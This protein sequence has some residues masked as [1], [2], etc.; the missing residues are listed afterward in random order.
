MWAEIPK[1]Q[2]ETRGGLVVNSPV[3]GWIQWWGYAALYSNNT[4]PKILPSGGGKISSA[5]SGEKRWR[6]F[7]KKM[8]TGDVIIIGMM[9]WDPELEIWKQ[10]RFYKDTEI[11][12]FEVPFFRDILDRKRDIFGVRDPDTG[13]TIN[14]AGEGILSIV[15]EKLTDPQ[16]LIVGPR[17]IKGQG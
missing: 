8:K 15:I 10:E 11:A 17:L 6:D 7:W 12:M 16:N 2:G 14:P 9:K 4:N 1:N 3:E 5:Y 13:L